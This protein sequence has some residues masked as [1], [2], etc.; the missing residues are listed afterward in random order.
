MH[1][2]SVY[3]TIVLQKR[4]FKDP[5]EFDYICKQLGVDAKKV[6]DDEIEISVDEVTFETEDD[7]A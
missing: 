4:W 1:K 5:E 6:S 7:D 3:E 2:K